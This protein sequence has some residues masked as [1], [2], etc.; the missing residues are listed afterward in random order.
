MHVT[1]KQVAVVAS[2]GQRRQKL[3]SNVQHM[4][5]WAHPRRGS[6]KLLQGLREADTCLCIPAPASK[7]SKSASPSPGYSLSTLAAA[8]Q[9]LR[10]GLTEPGDCII[11]DCSFLVGSSRELSLPRRDKRG[12]CGMRV[13]FLF[14][15]FVPREVRS[16]PVEAV[17]G[18]HEFA[19][20]LSSGSLCHLESIS[21]PRGRAVPV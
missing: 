20:G 15:P 11:R 8:S 17:V 4:P 6:E 21:V 13:H 14:P 1:N 5:I 19:V 3:W 2:F 7:N 18:F 12:G 9:N 16:T 10:S